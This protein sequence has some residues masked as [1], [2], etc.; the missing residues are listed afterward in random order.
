[1]RIQEEYILL[2]YF[3]TAGITT[4]VPN[5]TRITAANAVN[6]SKYYYSFTPHI[7]LKYR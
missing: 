7:S 4:P 6:V 3:Y 1:M 2:S 5:T